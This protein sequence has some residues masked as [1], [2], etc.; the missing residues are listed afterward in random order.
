VRTAHFTHALMACI[1][2]PLLADIVILACSQ[3][4]DQLESFY[5]NKS[6]C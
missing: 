4:L 1:Q 6:S 3:L 5:A 2:Y